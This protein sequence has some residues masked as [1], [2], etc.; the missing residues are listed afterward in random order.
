MLKDSIEKNQL[1]K[2][3]ESTQVNLSNSDYE[4]K[5][6]IQNKIKYEVTFSINPMLKDENEKKNS[7]KKN[8]KNSSQ[9]C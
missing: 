2:Y 5:I 1:K 6:N 7:I 8:K 4:T 3:P 9:P